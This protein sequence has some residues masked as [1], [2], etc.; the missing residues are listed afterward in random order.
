VLLA[1]CGSSSSSSSSS[2]A[3]S[4]PSTAAQSTPAPATTTATSTAAGGG[5]L[6]G[7]KHDKLGTIL[8]AGPKRRTVYLF[9]G[10]KGAA[11][12]CTG[13]CAKAWPPVTTSAA[14]LVAGAAM[15][16]DLGTITREDG[17]KQVTYKGHPLYFF[18]KDGDAADA[19]GQGVKAFGSSWYVL[20][21]SGVKIAKS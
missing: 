8:A 18:A 15:S 11:S 6:V 4:T 12:S 2:S 21:P 5:E 16:A 13:A 9:E 10:D 17:T 3:A 19:Y 14:P 20:K 1:G 7:S